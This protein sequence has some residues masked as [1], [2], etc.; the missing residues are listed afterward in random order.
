M[1]SLHVSPTKMTHPHLTHIFRNPTATSPPCLL[2]S[3]PYFVESIPSHR[4]SLYSGSGHCSFVFLVSPVSH[5][6]T[7]PGFQS[8]ILRMIIH[9][10][11]PMRF[12]AFGVPILD[13]HR[14]FFFATAALLSLFIWLFV[15]HSCSRFCFSFFQGIVELIS[16]TRRTDK[17]DRSYISCQK[18]TR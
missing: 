8:S 17:P 3:L 7:P 1:E 18:V 4:A 14:F 10:H 5:H 13:H 11:V 16:D 9:L 12:L 2:Q 15:A 6:T